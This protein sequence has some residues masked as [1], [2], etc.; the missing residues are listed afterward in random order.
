MVEL[1]QSSVLAQGSGSANATARAGSS[2]T[3]T[4]GEPEFAGQA[5]TTCEALV[6][7]CSV[8][9]GRRG[10]AIASRLG[11]RATR[12][13]DLDGV[14]GRTRPRPAHV[15][16]ARGRPV[17]TAWRADGSDRARVGGARALRPVLRDA[18]RVQAQPMGVRRPSQPRLPAEFGWTRIVRHQMVRHRASPDDPALSGCWAAR[19]RTAPPLPNRQD[20]PAAPRGAG[21]SLSALPGVAL[22]PP[23]TRRRPPGMGGWLASSRAVITETTAR[24]DGNTDE[25][26]L[27]LCHAHCSRRDA[28]HGRSP[29]LNAAGGCPGSP[30]GGVSSRGDSPTPK[31]RGSCVD[32]GRACCPSAPAGT[33][34]SWATELANWRGRP[35]PAASERGMVGS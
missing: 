15:T 12:P 17:W 25:P 1:S 34:A 28:A 19:R 13:L 20:Q 21:R 24:E 4:L 16:R 10:S 2:P 26:E 14:Y 35:R 11:N 30:S 23:R 22:N 31:P 3:I 7:G 33:G 5:R 6:D 9:G 18:P 27:R 29:A 8:R 32:R